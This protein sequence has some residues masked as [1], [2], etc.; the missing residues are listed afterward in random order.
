MKKLVMG[1]L[2]ALTVALNGMGCSRMGIGQETTKF[3]LDVASDRVPAARGVVEVKRADGNNVDIKVKVDHLAM[4]SALNP[5][6]TTY[7]VWLRPAEGGPVQ[8]IGV[9]PVNDKREGRFSTKTPFRQFEV[10]VTA[11][12]QANVTEPGG[13]QVLR[14]QVQPTGSGTF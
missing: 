1:V 2:V 12:R 13:L 4:P 10:F 7:V 6:A 8:N 5:E 11:E 14:A 3:P 9:M